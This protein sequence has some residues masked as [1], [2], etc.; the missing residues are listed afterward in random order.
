MI[1]RKDYEQR[2]RQ[3]L[4]PYAQL[5]GE[6]KGRDYHDQPCDTR[7]IFQQDRDRIIH[8]KAFRRLKH[9]TQ[10]FISPEGD[11]YRTRLTHT[12]EVAGIARTIAQ[13]LA[14]N[15]DLTETIALGHDLGHTPFGHAGEE[16]LDH[17]YEEGFR[18]NLQ[19]LRVV[20]L[21]EKRPGKEFRGLNLSIEVQDGIK[22]HTGPDKPETLEG[23]IVRIADRIAYINHDIDDAVRGGII[24]Y[25]DLPR[26]PMRILGKS[27]SERIDLMVRD[28]IKNSWNHDT[29]RQSSEVKD[30]MNKLRTWLFDNVYNSTSKAKTEESKAKN[31]LQKLYFYYHQHPQL[32]PEEFRALQENEE[33][34][35]IIIDYIAG[36]SDRY[37]LSKAHQFFFP[38]P[39]LK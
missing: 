20:K 15:E 11:H 13:G 34:S 12:L 1:I 25:E 28:I 14:L 6:S 17:V 2:E 21:L 26:E 18:H 3:F 32:I 33:I 23:Q 7:T 35:R 30:A 31:M 39:W 16:A 22:N 38:K 36:M 27:H 29:I 8:S 10:V 37:A 19:S 24:T 5:S 9:K 4:S